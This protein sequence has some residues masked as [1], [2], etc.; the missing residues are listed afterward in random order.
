M[1]ASLFHDIVAIVIEEI[2]PPH[3]WVSF[4]GTGFV[5]APGL[6]LTCWHCVSAP[7]ED[8]HQYAAI[9]EVELSNWE[10]FPL[11]NI[12]QD[13]NGFDLASANLDLNPAIGLKVAETNVIVGA[14]VW[15]GGYPYHDVEED[16]TAHNKLTLKPR[17]LKGYVCRNA[18][19]S[20]NPKVPCYDLDMPA[21]RGLSGGPVIKMSSEAIGKGS[22]DVIGVIYGANDVGVLEQ[23]SSVDPESGKHEP[24]I[25][26]VEYFGLAHDLETVRNLSG[27]ATN[28][29]PLT[30]YLRRFQL[31]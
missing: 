7:L 27:K 2:S 30:Q 9:A 26:R 16:I 25:Q 10:V 20:R 11:R 14:D 21:P 8:K 17:L 23:V 3:H 19:D 22:A 31:V 6:V 13:G 4:Q 5:I 18:F 29:L 15:T 1:P 12:E 24:E 28:R